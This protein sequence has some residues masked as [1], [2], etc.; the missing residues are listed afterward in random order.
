MPQMDGYELAVA[1]R[2]AEAD[3][4]RMPI[5]A[6]TANALKGEARR[7]LALGMDDYMTKPVQLANLKAMLCK[8]MPA[9]VTPTPVPD[10]PEPPSPAAPATARA[11]DVSVLEALV[12]DD[13]QV[14]EEFLQD[15]RVSAGEASVQMRAACQ[16]RQPDAVEAVA[17]RLKSSARAVGA[18]ALGELCAEME[19]AGQAGQLDTLAH[20]W[21]R[22]EAELAAVDKCLEASQA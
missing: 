4:R 2:E 8:W 3:Q 17:H 20:L 22:F 9:T 12:G 10:R 13:P 6:L 1:I 18:L 21:P 15:F 11:L 16:D 14:I 5:V 19:E 7:C